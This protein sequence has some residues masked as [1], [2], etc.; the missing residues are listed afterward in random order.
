MNLAQFCFEWLQVIDDS[1]GTV[2]SSGGFMLVWGEG[3]S[4]EGGKSE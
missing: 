2:N 3:V 1:E 4:G